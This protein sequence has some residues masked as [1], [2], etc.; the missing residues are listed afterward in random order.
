MAQDAP[1]RTEGSNPPIEVVHDRNAQDRDTISG[2]REERS[3]DAADKAAPRDRGAASWPP[4]RTP[5]RRYS[6]LPNG[7]RLFIS[8]GAC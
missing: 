2:G 6:A 5:Y 1:D 4:A 7:A 8:A 3:R